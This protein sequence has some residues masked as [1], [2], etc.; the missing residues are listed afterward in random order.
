M[1]ENR[2][3]FRGS[4][5]ATHPPPQPP[6][7]QQTAQMPASSAPPPKAMRNRKTA[8]N[9][10]GSTSTVSAGAA[11]SSPAPATGSASTRA[12]KQ[13]DQHLQKHSMHQEHP[14]ENQGYWQARGRGNLLASLHPISM[15]VETIECML[16]ICVLLLSLC[17]ATKCVLCY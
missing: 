1:Q 15:L 3:I 6:P 14:L 4:S 13:E 9:K 2:E 12:A 16:L 8:A 7:Q 17:S 11:R 10:R 5:S